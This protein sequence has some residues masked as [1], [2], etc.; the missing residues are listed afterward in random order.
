MISNRQRY[1]QSIEKPHTKGKQI[2]LKK[3]GKNELTQKKKLFSPKCLL[4]LQ[5]FVVVQFDFENNK[6]M[7]VKI[8][9]KI[10]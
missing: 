8:E 1:A 10:K 3:E 9:M 5:N 4:T 6:E 7:M 2:A